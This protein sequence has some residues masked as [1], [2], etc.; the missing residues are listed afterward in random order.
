[1]AGYYPKHV[2]AV[3]IIVHFP[4]SYITYTIFIT[5]LLRGVLLLLI[6]APKCFGHLQRARKF[7][8]VCSLCVT[9]C[10]GDSIHYCP[11]VIKMTILK[12]LKSIYGNRKLFQFDTVVICCVQTSV[13]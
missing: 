5:D 3:F 7:F 13:F 1:M 8:D 9:L 12:P 6:I 11:I 10:G 2:E 4:C